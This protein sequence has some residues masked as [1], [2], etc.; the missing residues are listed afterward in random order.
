MPVLYPRA[1]YVPAAPQ[2][3]GGTLMVDNVRLIVAHVTQ[4]SRQS[5][6]DSW[7]RNPTAQVSAHF[8]VSRFG[9][10][11]QHVALDRMAWAEADY[12]DVAF[13]IEHLGYSGQRLT[14]L[15]LRATLRLMRWLHD[16][17]PTIPLRRTANP[18]GRGVIGHGE[19][20]QSGGDHP[21]CPGHPI[22]AQLAAALSR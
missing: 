20:G 19:L 11:H 18:A 8:S 21:D 4:G 13:S 10:V 12:N 14:R 15:Q 3:V 5:G 22:L 16:Q 6:I 7:F 17:V 9:V 1:T 2:N